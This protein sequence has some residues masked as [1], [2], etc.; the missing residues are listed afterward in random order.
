[1]ST[2]ENL[3]AGHRQRLLEK[4]LIDPKVFSDHEILELLLFY[5][6]PRK[7]TNPLAHR[8]LSVFGSLEKVFSATT[9]QL[10][11]V[12]GVGKKVAVQLSMMGE[13]LGRFDKNEE[14]KVVKVNSLFD[15][16]EM[17]KPYFNGLGEEIFV[18]LLLDDKHKLISDIRVNHDL[19]T[20]VGTSVEMLVESFNVHR[21][22]YAIVAHN[23][24]SGMVKPSVS[25]DYSTK[26]INVLCELYNVS[27]LDHVIYT[28]NGVYSY[29]REGRMEDI[30]KNCNLNRIFD[31]F[32]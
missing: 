23:H 22:K 17:L 18:L 14:K 13:I 15:V 20:S 3:H 9:E 12:D 31:T 7:D 6:V 27:L 10:L 2:E 29:E 19:E 24:P 1:M 32:K 28:N 26:K 21:P 30:K 4:Y 25:D 11:K 5:S 16:N 8:L